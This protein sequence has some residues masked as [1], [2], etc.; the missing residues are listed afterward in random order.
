MF[1]TK[2]NR[3]SPAAKSNNALSLTWHLISYFC[4]SG[5]FCCNRRDLILPNNLPCFSCL[6][7]LVL[8]WSRSCCLRDLVQETKLTS[9]HCSSLHKVAFFPFLFPAALSS[10]PIYRDQIADKPPTVTYTLA[11]LNWPL[12]V[13]L[14]KA[15]LC[16]GG[17]SIQLGEWCRHGLRSVYCC[18]ECVWAWHHPGGGVN[19]GCRGISDKVLG[20]L[21]G[22]SGDVM[23]T[24]LAEKR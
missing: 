20:F 12:P 21:W 4:L 23:E 7:C 15:S 13:H 24:E 3:T 14:L 18:C 22:I 1:M 16:R 17:R 8:S 5:F 6:L 10:E 11:W 2:I 9:F 19:E